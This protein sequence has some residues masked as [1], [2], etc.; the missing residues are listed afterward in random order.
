MPKFDTK[1]IT[2][3]KGR[4]KFVQ[5]TIDDD[6]DFTTTTTPD[7]KN[8]CKHGVLDEFEASL[9]ANEKEHFARIITI[10]ERVANL[11]PV[12]HTQFKDLNGRKKS[13]PIKDY[14]FKCGSLRVYAA[15]MPNGKIVILGG[16]KNKQ[17]E[18]IRKMR[19]RKKQY[20]D[21]LKNLKK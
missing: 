10:M 16:Y 14:E 12:P 4:Q 18:D 2:A 17:T 15:D 3:V 8:D 9:Q 19:S 7:E 21:S 6:P 11:Q 5:L 20:F 1:T 13:D